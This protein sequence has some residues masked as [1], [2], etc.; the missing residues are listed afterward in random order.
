[1]K[2]VSFATQKQSY[3]RNMTTPLQIS[4]SDPILR[5]SAMTSHYISPEEAHL[6]HVTI[7]TGLNTSLVKAER[8]CWIAIMTKICI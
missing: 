1:M 4:I 7:A 6:F 8:I 5:L 3:A 2:N